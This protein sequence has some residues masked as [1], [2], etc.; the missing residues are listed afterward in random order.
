MLELLDGAFAPDLSITCSLIVIIVN[1]LSPK[2]SVYFIRFPTSF[3]RK[4]EKE[5]F[6]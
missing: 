2:I 6:T 4:Y 1:Y 5:A 3:I